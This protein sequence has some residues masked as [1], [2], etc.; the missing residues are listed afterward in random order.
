MKELLIFV[1]FAFVLLADCQIDEEE[2]NE[3]NWYSMQKRKIENEK[4]AQI[5]RE[6]EKEERLAK[7]A[8]DEKLSKF[9]EPNWYS[10]QKKA[11]EIEKLA[12]TKREEERLAKIARDEKLSKIKAKKAKMRK[13]DGV[14]ERVVTMTQKNMKNLLKKYNIVIVLFHAQTNA[15]IL[16]QEKY[17]LEAINFYYSMNVN[18]LF[19]E[20]ENHKREKTRTK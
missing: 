20:K 1:L 18:Q 3:R 19:H 7:I 14:D 15:T 10:I 8:R 16:K 4:L 6:E 11:T 13:H 2:V 5:K 12:Q 17:P 9:N